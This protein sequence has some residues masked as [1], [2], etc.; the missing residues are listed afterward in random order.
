MQ[1]KINRSLREKYVDVK[2]I[3]LI[4]SY[5]MYRPFLNE[6]NYKTFVHMIYTPAK[7]YRWGVNTNFSIFPEDVH[8]Q[9]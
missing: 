8:L 2:Y 1:G 7:S 4:Y 3:F 6:N 9:F 5:I